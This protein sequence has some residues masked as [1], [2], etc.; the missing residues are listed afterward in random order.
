LKYDL[1]KVLRNRHDKACSILE[2]NSKTPEYADCC[3]ELRDWLPSDGNA[4]DGTEEQASGSENPAESRKR[5]RV[6][7]KE[8]EEEQ[9]LRR[10]KKETSQA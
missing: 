8:K 6:S 4:E 9:C 5:T 3:K 10:A 7:E 1:E 2:E